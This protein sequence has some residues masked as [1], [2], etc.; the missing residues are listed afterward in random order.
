MLSF[1]RKKFLAYI[2]ETEKRLAYEIF[3]AMCKQGSYKNN[4]GCCSSHCPWPLRELQLYVNDS[5]RDCANSFICIDTNLF[6]VLLIQIYFTYNL[7]YFQTK[8]FYVF[9][10]ATATLSK[11]LW[12]HWYKWSC[13]HRVAVASAVVHTQSQLASGLWTH[14]FQWRI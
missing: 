12:L 2:T 13:L 10:D 8:L 9:V 7:F 6:Y 1:E 3:F 4:S 5:W 14:N 11:Q